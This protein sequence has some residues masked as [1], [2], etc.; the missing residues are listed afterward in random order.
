MQQVLRFH[1]L[2]VQQSRALGHQILQ[3]IRVFHQHLHH[4][5]HDVP[6]PADKTISDEFH[7]RR[8]ES[9]IFKTKFKIID[10]LR[11]KVGSCSV[12]LCNIKTLI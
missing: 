2:L 3:V 9:F 11:G 12:C 8:I 6:V 7:G 5:V 10:S 1:L 4:L